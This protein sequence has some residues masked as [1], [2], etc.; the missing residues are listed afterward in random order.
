MARVFLT[1]GSGFLG[2]QV[3]S[4]LV[5]RGHEVT[6]LARN[7]DGGPGVVSGDLLTPSSYRDALTGADVVI[8]LAA[9]TG[10]ARAADYARVNVDGTRMLLEATAS[11][12]VSRFLFC[13]SI[14]TTFPDVSGY[15]YA[16][17]K[18]AA[19][20]LV[21][22][23]GLSTTIVRPTIIAGAGSPVMAKLTT[24]ARLPIV[25][26]FGGGH[27]RVQPIAVADLAE[28]V[29]DLVDND[30]FAGEILEIG[31]RDVL[32][33]RELVTRLRATANLS[34]GRTVNL[35]MSV[36]VPTLG[37]LERL[38]GPALPI[39][40]GQ[41]AT[42]RFDG[43]ARPNMLVDARLDRLARLEDWLNAARSDEPIDSPNVLTEE[44]HAL[45]RAIAGR[46]PSPYVVSKYVAAH[47][48]HP[49]LTRP[50]GFDAT[51]VRWARRG[52]LLTR[53]ADGYARRAVPRGTLRK[54]LVLLLAIIETAPGFRPSV[55][56]T[57]R[58]SPVAV[59]LRL[60]LLGVTGFLV[61][62]GGAV[63]FGPLQLVSRSPRL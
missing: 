14:A 30:Q 24:L 34:P 12:G 3:Q 18:R 19:E 53:L 26:L 33:L 52:P 13:S 7:G 22:A 29:V 4:A 27:N 55:E 45:T 9:V 5:G 50:R 42:F 39:T 6:A 28:L 25:P 60:V 59:V 44:C 58:V 46:F 48:V 63:L 43:V 61:T 23:S 35:P 41:L 31:G 56:L 32:T 49:D 37:L 47:R 11:A 38:V 17:S 20:A 15:P 62:I 54:K 2:R 8:H 40:V 10:K 36:L 1:G 21:Q 51:L 57:D 16:E